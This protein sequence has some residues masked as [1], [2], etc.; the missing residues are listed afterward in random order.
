MDQG[1]HQIQVGDAGLA[2]AEL[3][4]PVSWDGPGEHR[5][6]PRQALGARGNIRRDRGRLRSDDAGGIRQQ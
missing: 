5:G 4:H 1:P 6:P 3:G 2:D